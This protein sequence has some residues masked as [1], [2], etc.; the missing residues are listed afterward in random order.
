MLALK[1]SVLLLV[2][3]RRAEQ[4]LGQ[5]IATLRCQTSSPTYYRHCT[6]LIAETSIV[7]RQ[8]LH[9]SSG[10][11]LSRHDVCYIFRKLLWSGQ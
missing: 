1:P 4:T 10:H 5:A 9:D 2:F 3:Q 6:D 8:K 11:R 7:H